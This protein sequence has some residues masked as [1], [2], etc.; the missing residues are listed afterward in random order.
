VVTSA[1]S[2]TNCLQL[3]DDTFAVLAQ[4]LKQPD[5]GSNVLLTA[6]LS[7]LA[8][9][10]ATIITAYVQNRIEKSRVALARAAKVDESIIG[11]LSSMIM[12]PSRD[13][14]KSD[15]ERA[16]TQLLFSL[17]ATLP[18]AAALASRLRAAPEPDDADFLGW[19]EELI[20]AAAAYFE[21]MR[22]GL[23]TG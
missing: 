14:Q 5:H 15:F 18:T 3:T 1:L 10:L 20:A 19:R 9:I 11:N 2:S 8:A 16:K 6:A 13:V 12:Y 22:R 4:A 17:P 23:I 21:D 7:A